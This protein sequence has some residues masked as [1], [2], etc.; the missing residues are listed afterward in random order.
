[1]QSEKKKLDLQVTEIEAR[2]K[3]ETEQLKIQNEQLNAQVDE[4][5]LQEE[6][7]TEEIENMK[8]GAAMQGMARHGT[9][10]QENQKYNA[11]CGDAGHGTA[12][13]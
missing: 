4:L 10:P 7:H 6:S 3:A 8:P 2:Y 12:R 5:Q 9:K 1:M 13:N 11:R